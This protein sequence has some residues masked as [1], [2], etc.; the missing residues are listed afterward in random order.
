MDINNVKDEKIDD[1]DFR[2]G[3]REREGEP[4]EIREIDKETDLNMNGEPVSVAETAE[5]REVVEGGEEGREQ[6]GEEDDN[7]NVE[8]EN[9]SL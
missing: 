2:E 8:K 1:Y 7:M 5:E 9:E 4:F 6:G 3:E